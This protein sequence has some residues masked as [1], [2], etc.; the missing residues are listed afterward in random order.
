MQL[1]DLHDSP[2]CD[3]LDR[4]DTVDVTR[5]G[6]PDRTMVGLWKRSTLH[7]LARHVLTDRTVMFAKQRRG[8]KTP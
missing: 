8:S 7:L 6:G 4:F 2:P 5:A 3:D 1:H